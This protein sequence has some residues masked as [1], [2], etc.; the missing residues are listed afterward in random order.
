MAN[1]SLPC[2]PWPNVQDKDGYPVI[3]IGPRGDA[4]MY[5]VCRLLITEW[6]GRVLPKGW[7]PD[8]LCGNP[9]CW[10]PAHLEPVTQRENT[11]RSN[12]SAAQNA[13]K[14]HCVNGHP[15]DEANT[16]RARGR[17]YCRAC[18]RVS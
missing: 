10:E 1:L 5:R 16:Y 17:R 11:L 18:R 14:T 7:E 2:D 15:F 12:N 8:H 6:F 9:S 4:F 13:R 3:E